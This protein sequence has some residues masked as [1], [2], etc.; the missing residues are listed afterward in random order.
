MFIYW[1]FFLNMHK[2]NNKLNFN[3]LILFL[4]K[5]LLFCS[6]AY[7][8]L[9]NSGP[10]CV[11]G[12]NKATLSQHHHYQFDHIYYYNVWISIILKFII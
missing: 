2:W 11:Q 4:L 1:Y 6:V 5:I 10:L 7:I 8:P 12:E 9:V 3:S